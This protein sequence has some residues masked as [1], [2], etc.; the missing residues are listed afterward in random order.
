[1]SVHDI[2]VVAAVTYVGSSSGRYKKD[3]R[4]RKNK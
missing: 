3:E 4:R 2:I 1:M